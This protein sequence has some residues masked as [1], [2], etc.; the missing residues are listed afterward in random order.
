LSALV[1]ALLTLA[2]QIEVVFA[3]HPRTRRK[4]EDFDLLKVIGADARIRTT[5]PLSYID[6]MN[7][8]MHARIAITDSGGIQEETTYLGIP[9]ATLR[10]NTE[11]PITVTEGTNRLLKPGDL[12]AAVREALAGT[13]PKGHCPE[14]WDG[15]AAERAAMSLKMFFSHRSGAELPQS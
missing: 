13:W 4:L 15:H 11:R 7:L 14:L 8:V 12:P 1:A 2:Q 10:E 6:F 5:D 9:C 3:I